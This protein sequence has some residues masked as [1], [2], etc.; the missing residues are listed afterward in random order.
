MF[1]FSIED[2]IAFVIIIAGSLLRFYNFDGWS[3]SN[4]E[5]S[6][7]TRLKYDSFSEMIEKGVRT[8]DMHPPGVQ[9]F[10]WVWT[11]L[12]GTADSIV[13]L[14]F[15]LAGALS[16]WLFYL[17]GIR[18]FGK[19][20]ALLSTAAFAALQFPLL[21]SQLA[22]PYSP[23]L[24]FSLLTVYAWSGLLWKDKKW[25]WKNAFL[26]I[27]GG[28]GCMYSHYFSFMFAGLVGI[29]GLFFLKKERWIAYI[30]CGMAMFVFYIPALNVL[31]TQFSIGGLGGPE[32]WLGPPSKDALWKYLLFCLNDSLPLLLFYILFSSIVLILYRRNQVWSKQHTVSLILFISPAL[33]AY[34]YS[35]YRNP[36]FQYSILLFNFPFLLLLLFSWFQPLQFTSKHVL[37]LLLIFCITLY[38]TV[39]ANHFYSH[40]FFA[41]FSDVAEK[42]AF[43]T[44]KYEEAGVDATIN[45]IHPDYIKHYSGKLKPVVKFLQYEC[46]RPEQLIE[47]KKLLADSRARCFI[48]AWS[49]NYHAPETDLMIKEYFPFLVEKD[50]F[51]NAGVL[52]YSKDSTL[53]RIS[54]PPPLYEVST[55]FEDNAWTADTLFKTD[56]IF[57]SGK[58]SMIISE[59]TEFSPG[60]KDRAENIGFEK[61]A[62]FLLNFKYFSHRTTS[63]L[64]V[65]V[66][67]DRN[68]ETILWRGY[69]LHLYPPAR[70]GWTTYYAGYKL[71][72]NILA[73]DFVSVYFY[74]PQKERVWID[75]LSFRVFPW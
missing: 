9:S 41:P 34:Y 27:T 8:N 22:R 63:E 71:Q 28:V 20:A 75:E 51:F 42:C 70:S 19:P 60:I 14:P 44:E 13:R 50:S 65:V 67:V 26:F 54:E 4:D 21:Y 1:R 64:K 18:F 31:V 17:T 35:V 16:V 46:N 57:C 72:E 56:S 48:H 58:K 73:D 45:V 39:F 38:S 36:V 30:A 37:P 49:N 24:F 11:H 10:L 40:Q 15:V 69:P 12:F 61:G 66:S 47:L 43:Y 5:L 2:K 52:V 33:I 68:G 62:V 55:G 7:L 6:A 53:K 23:G 59:S 25:N 29:L 74:N 3:L 32:G